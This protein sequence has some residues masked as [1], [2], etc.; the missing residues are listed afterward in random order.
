MSVKETQRDTALSESVHA[1]DQQIASPHQLL[2]IPD[3]SRLFNDPISLELMVSASVDWLVD[4]L[5]P[6]PS[7]RP[8]VI[9]NA[10]DAAHR[11]ATD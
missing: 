11:T 4:H 2:E 5:A 9:D 3:A 1:L 6:D 7:D 8:P 10:P